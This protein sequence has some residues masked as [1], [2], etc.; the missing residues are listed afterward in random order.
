MT[1]W[2]RPVAIGIDVGGTHLRAGLVAADGSVT[3][4]VRHSSDVADPTALVTSVI[5]AIDDIMT[6]ATA[7][8][9]A[10][11]SEDLLALPVGLG[12][13]GLVTVEGDFLYGPNVGVEGIALRALLAEATG[14][15]VRVINDATAAVVAEQRVGA[16]RGHEDVVMLTLGTGVGGGVISGGR[17]LVGANGLASELGHIIIEDGGR[18]AP[19]GIRGT[20]EG[21]TSGSAIERAAAAAAALGDAG[22]RALDAPGI[23]AAAAQGEDWARVILED[24]GHWLAVGVASLSAV[25]DPSIVVIGGGAGVAMAPWVLPVVRAELP[26]LLMGGRVRPAIPVVLAELGDDAGLVGAALAADGA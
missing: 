15:R 22:A 5:V 12:F 16:A 17:L 13:A 9:D 24:A 7:G 4:L 2:G 14:R 3:G 11:R 8:E 6:A 26:A 25:L 23:V 19:S 18:D 10:A 21:Y 20:L 1:T